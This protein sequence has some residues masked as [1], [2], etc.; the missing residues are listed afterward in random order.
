MNQDLSRL[1]YDRDDFRVHYRPW[2]V[3]LA[4]LGPTDG[5]SGRWFA[6]AAPLPTFV[7]RGSP[8]YEIIA[9]TA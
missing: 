2:I 6:G 8:T 7:S 9:S 4:R 3:Y 5:K 1:M